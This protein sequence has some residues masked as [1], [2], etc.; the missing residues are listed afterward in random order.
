M[1]TIFEFSLRFECLEFVAMLP[2]HEDY[3]A[4]ISRFVKDHCLDENFNSSVFKS[5]SRPIEI[6][7]YMSAPL[8]HDEWN[9]KHRTYDQHIFIL[10]FYFVID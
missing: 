10:Y 4:K 6:L 3:F 5:V 7:I 9:L 8:W 2:S 1:A